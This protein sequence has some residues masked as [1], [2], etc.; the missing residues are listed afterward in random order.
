MAQQE[1]LL[2][3]PSF[4]DTPS[5]SRPPR[6]WQDCGFVNE[7]PPDVQPGAFQ[8]SLPASHG[9]TYLGL[10]VRDNETYEAVGQHLSSPL[11]AGNCYQ[12]SLNV[13]RSPI[14]LSHSR[15]TGA[16]ADYIGAAVLRIWGGTASCSRSELLY[17][18]DSILNTNWSTRTIKLQPKKGDYNYLIFEAFYRTPVM[19]PYNGNILLDNITPIRSIPCNEPAVARRDSK[20]TDPNTPPTEQEGYRRRSRG[21][22]DLVP[23]SSASEKHLPLDTSTQ[24]IAEFLDKQIVSRGPLRKGAVFQI[25]NLYFDTNQY[26]IKEECI[27]VLE[28]L[29]RFMIDNPNVV[30]E[31]GGHTNNLPSDEFAMELSTNRAK[32][33]AEWLIKKGIPEVRVQYRGYGKTQPLDSNLTPEGRRRNQRVEFKIISV[34]EN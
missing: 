22:G 6:G 30:I 17:Q 7:S 28:A 19:F 12:F 3:N 31:I 21:K 16:R 13:C 15:T 11:K 20:P 33:V 2:E 23:L 18:T 14:Y 34:S 1:I 5:P 24:N 25:S 26:S 32:A 27:P 8:V 29:Y 10:V 9:Q 4:E